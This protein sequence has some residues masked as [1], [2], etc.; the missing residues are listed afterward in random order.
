MPVQLED[1]VE[2]WQERKKT[3]DLMA[4]AG[5]EGTAGDGTDRDGG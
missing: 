1:L 2:R 4:S 5:A 3:P